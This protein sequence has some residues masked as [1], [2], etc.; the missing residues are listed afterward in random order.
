[1]MM[2][3]HVC[4]DR[5]LL[6]PLSPSTLQLLP[7]DHMRLGK[8]AYILLGGVAGYS[9]KGPMTPLGFPLSVIGGQQT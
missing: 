2:V 6:S 8:I 7:K 4:V 5:Y 1:M 9:G 3:F